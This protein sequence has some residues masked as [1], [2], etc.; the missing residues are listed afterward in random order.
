M[1]SIGVGCCR[2]GGGDSFQALHKGL[3]LTIKLKTKHVVGFTRKSFESAR[4]LTFLRKLT[5]EFKA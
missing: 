3:T 4:F 2:W 5:I 1:V